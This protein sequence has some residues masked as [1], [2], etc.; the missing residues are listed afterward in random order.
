M[1]GGGN[2]VISVKI[3]DPKFFSPNKRKLVSSGGGLVS[4]VLSKHLNNIY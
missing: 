4:F 3:P 1:L 2:S